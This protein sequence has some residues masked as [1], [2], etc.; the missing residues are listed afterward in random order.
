MS[1]QVVG[2]KVAV[3]V[4]VQVAVDDGVGVSGWCGSL[5][6]L[7]EKILEVQHHDGVSTLKVL[8]HRAP[9]M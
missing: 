4:G 6:G 8:Q 9:I 2:V 5:G 3:D 1:R 7:D